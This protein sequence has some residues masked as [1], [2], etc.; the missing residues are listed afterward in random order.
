MKTRLILMRSLVYVFYQFLYKENNAWLAELLSI[1]IV[2]LLSFIGWE[3]NPR[4]EHLPKRNKALGEISDRAHPKQLLNIHMDLFSTPSFFLS[5]S[6][7]TR[8]TFL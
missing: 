3:C 6:F 1:L 2:V 4:I 8:N 5:P 7:W